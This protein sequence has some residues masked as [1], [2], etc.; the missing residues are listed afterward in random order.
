MA[1]KKAVAKR[2][3]HKVCNKCGVNNPLN[4]RQCKSCQGTK[5]AP[6]WVVAKR[7]VNRQVSVEVTT[8][9]PQ[10][11][12]S[13][14]RLTL[15]KWW[16]GGRSTFHLP[17]ASQWQSIQDI[18]NADLGPL[19]GWE[20]ANDIIKSIKKKSATG[21]RGA[22]DDDYRKLIESYPDFLKKLVAAIDPKNLSGREFD[23][24]VQTFGDISDALTNANSGFR[25]AF[26]G[27]VS[28]LPKQK[29]RALEDLE[30]LLQGWSLQVVT[31]V[32]QQ[33][34]ARMETIELFEKQAQDEKTFE[35]KGD[36]SI[37]RI[38]KRAMWMIDER[39]WLLQSN[40]TLRK[41][42]GDAMSKKDRKRFGD[43]RPD[44]VCGTVESRLILLE[45]KRPSHTLSVGDLNQ[46]E[47]YTVVAEDYKNFS[48]YEGYL[49]GTQEDAELRRYLKRRSGFR[50]LHFAD[51]IERTRTRYRDFLKAIDLDT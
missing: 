29:Q 33:V 5:F 2:R 4:A 51:I 11:G 28:K 31:N 47:A 38:L 49:V 30:L 42:I 9:N 35:I 23:S 15:S 1:K 16:P 48:S 7:P 40:N 3:T 18:I 36:N 12:D 19:I 10:F 34:K 24:V 41:F 8:S 39:Y 46:L 45:L 27:V 25:A 43:K 22:A 21:K 14:E 44:F 32:A 26:L 20:A 13:V 6:A 37:H 17:N 50:V